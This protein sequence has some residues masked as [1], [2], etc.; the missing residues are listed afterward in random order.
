[1]IEVK[2]DVKPREGGNKR[3]R[4]KG[5]KGKLVEI[6]DGEIIRSQKSSKSVTTCPGGVFKLESNH[7]QKLG[8][9]EDTPIDISV[10]MSSEYYDD[11][12]SDK[13]MNSH[14]GYIQTLLYHLLI[15]I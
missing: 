8:I 1:M 3:K 9:Y 13:S 6:R 14:D 7:V 4:K 5:H 12:M 15:G 11:N 10:R 2:Y